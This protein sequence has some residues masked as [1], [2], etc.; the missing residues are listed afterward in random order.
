MKTQKAT[1][2]KTKERNKERESTEADKAIHRSPHRQQ[3]GDR[4]EATTTR[5]WRDPGQDR[6][7]DR[8]AEP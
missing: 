6:Q 5:R 3:E 4:P 8:L 2:K 7:G 1:A